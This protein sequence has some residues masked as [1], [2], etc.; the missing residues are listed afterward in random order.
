VARKSRA[1]KTADVGETGL[2]AMSSVLRLHRLMTSIAEHQLGAGFQLRLIEYQMLMTLQASDTGS[3]LLG[4][5]ARQLLVHPTTVTT[6]TDRLE[7]RGLVARHAD[8]EDRRA[9]LVTITDNGRTLV[10]AATK[11]LSRVNFGLPGLSAAQAK[12]LI[13]LA[14]Q[15]QPPRVAQEGTHG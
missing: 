4:R 6:A 10:D 8:P 11:A 5:V 14:E 3:L 2:R 12:Q 13:S 7:A 15:P 9:T 1:G